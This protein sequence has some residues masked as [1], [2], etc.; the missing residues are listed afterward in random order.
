MRNRKVS[1]NAAAILVAALMLLTAYSNEWIMLAAAG[2]VLVG[3]FVLHGDK[4]ARE[5]GLSAV[6]AAAIALIVTLAMILFLGRW[7]LTC[8]GEFENLYIQ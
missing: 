4:G 6:A 3:M 5:E 1:G 8:R 2:F 7:G